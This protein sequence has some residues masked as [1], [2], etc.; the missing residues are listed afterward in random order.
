MELVPDEDF[1]VEHC[2]EHFRLVF[3]DHYS[4]DEI[5][6]IAEAVDGEVGVVVVAH[7]VNLVQETVLNATRLVDSSTPFDYLHLIQHSLRQVEIVHCFS[8]FALDKIEVAN[9]GALDSCKEDHPVVVVAVV[10]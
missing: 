5:G 8:S 7:T 6:K 4:Y 10:D 2:V 3:A 9:G 1:V